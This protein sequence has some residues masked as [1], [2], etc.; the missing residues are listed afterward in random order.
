[1]ASATLTVRPFA[2]VVSGL[3]LSGTGNPGGSIPTDAVFGK[4]GAAFSATVGAYRWATG[5]D[6]NSDGVPDAASTLAQVTAGGLTA[7]YSSSVTLTPLAA[8][9]TP[10]PANGG[11]L[12]TLSNNVISGFSA[13]TV[14]ASNLTYSEAGSFQLNTSAVVGNF[15]ASGLA[16]D[17]TVFNASGGAVNRVGRFIPAGFVVSGFVPSHRSGL[18]CSP[19]STFTYL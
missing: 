5:A 17:A 8:S 16:L 4:A 10:T 12:G 2:I 1:M 7:S 14:T 9:Q 11:V 13:G 15:L 6:S 3:T 19:A 18:T